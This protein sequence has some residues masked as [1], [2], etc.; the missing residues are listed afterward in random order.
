[1]YAFWEALYR[2]SE[3]PNLRNFLHLLS[4]K[5]SKNKRGT[6][7]IIQNFADMERAID[8][9]NT[10]RLLRYQDLW[11]LNEVQEKRNLN[12]F[13]NLLF[14]QISFLWWFCRPASEFEI[15]HSS[16]FYDVFLME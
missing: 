8:K 11:L 14:L 3:T 12:F 9:S 15:S 2:H 13:K 10:H 7:A 16:K 1:M 4:M 5:H 6:N